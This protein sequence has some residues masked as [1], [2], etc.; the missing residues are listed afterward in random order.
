MFGRIHAAAVTR[1]FDESAEA[2]VFES[3]DELL[4]KHDRKKA[5]NAALGVLCE[6][7]MNRIRT[8]IDEYRRVKWKELPT[9]VTNG[10][11]I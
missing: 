3:W 9:D 2:G 1:T 8:G 6:P 4:D 7:C 10:C 5:G 11:R